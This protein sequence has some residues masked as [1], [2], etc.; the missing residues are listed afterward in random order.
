MP[1]IMG[2]LV[3]LF[4]VLI[5]WSWNSLGN[6]DKNKKVINIIVGVI[7]VYLFTLIIYSI[8]KSGINY[9]NKE[10]MKTIQNVFVFLFTTVNGYIILPYIFKKIN[11]VKSKEIEKENLKKSIVIIGI[12]MIILTIFE[13]NYFSNIQQQIISNQAKSQIENKE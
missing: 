11:Q 6:V 13:I 8:S 2:I 4:L 3:L 5:A 1:I 10:A 9:E 12:I 7:V